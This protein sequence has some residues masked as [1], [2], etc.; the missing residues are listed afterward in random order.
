M[1]PTVAV[2]QARG[3]EARPVRFGGYSVGLFIDDIPGLYLTETCSRIVDSTF[4]I[5]SGDARNRRFAT[6]VGVG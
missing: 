3:P 4:V 6:M 2:L 1:Q 5:N